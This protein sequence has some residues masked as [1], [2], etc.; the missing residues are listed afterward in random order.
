MAYLLHPTAVVDDSYFP[1]TQVFW[2]RLL[3][4]GSRQLVLPAI[5][6]ALK[7]KNLQQHAPKDL[8][9][10][11][12]EITDLNYK[13]NTA[14]LKQIKYIS[15]IFNRNEIEYVFL[16]GSAMLIVKPYDVK[17]DRMIGDIDIL[18]SEKD[19]LRSQQ[20]LINEGFKAVSNEFNF[21]KG[22]LSNKL[23]RHLER[24]AHPEHIAAVEIHR[25]LLS[26]QNHL[27]APNDILETKVRCRKDLFIPS[28]NYLWQHAILNWKYNDN[29]A[30]LNY[31][32]FRSV[33]DIFYL[34]P[35]DFM[36]K[37]KIAPEATKHFYTLLSLYFDNYKSYYILRKL[38]YKWQLES[39]SFYK[40]Y[41]FYIK[42]KRL[43]YF[44]FLRTCLFLS[45]NIY[46]KRVLNNPRLIAHRIYNFWNK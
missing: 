37:L 16:K 23:N 29:G 5:Y 11:L 30:N 12:H 25:H 8:L 24:I 19:L 32:S 40:L 22:V 1:A 34:R 13:R 35:I 9:S 44:G 39:R 45:S 46:R 18:V 21:T 42:S 10:Y 14:I 27:I 4:L 20:L 36:E 33:L 17:S 6:G 15:Q 26:R 41:S 31:L 7:R 43:I 2:D 3:Q 38:I 28:K